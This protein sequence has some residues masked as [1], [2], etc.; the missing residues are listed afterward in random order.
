MGKVLECVVFGNT[1]R[2]KNR[3]GYLNVTKKMDSEQEA[4]RARQ[5]LAAIAL[6]GIERLRISALD[7]EHE[8][9]QQI[10]KLAPEFRRSAIN[11]LHYL[12][13]RH[14]DIREL[15]GLL[16]QLGMSSLGRMEAHVM[17][18]LNAVSELLSQLLNLAAQQGQPTLDIVTFKEGPELL[19]RNAEAIMGP[20]VPERGTRIMVTMPSEASADPGLVKDLLANGMEIMRINCAHDSAVE[21]RRMIDHLKDAETALGRHCK[22]SFDLAGPKLRTGSLAA[23]EPVIKVKPTRNALGNV[24]MPARMLLSRVESLAAC[25]AGAIP[26]DGALPSKVKIGD[27][28]RLVDA[29]GRKRKLIVVDKSDEGC[30]C[31]ASTTTYLVPGTLFQFSR[32]KHQLGKVPVAE[33]RGEHQAIH[34][35]PGDTLTLTFGDESGCDAIRDDSGKVVVP[36]SLTCSLSEV[37]R[38][39]RPG[40]RIFFDDGK[41]GGVIGQVSTERLVI[42]IMHVVGGKA[43]LSGEKGINLPDSHLD[44]P[45]L[46]VKD[47]Q[48]MEFAVDHADMLA[49]SFVQRPE[50]I[51]QLVGEL[52][53]LGRR[54]LGI[55]LKIETQ[56]AFAELPALLLEAMK[57]YPVA[58][59]VARG[60]LGV[61]VGFERLAE[62]QEE[63]LWLCEA[64]HVP[65]IWATQVLESLAKGGLPSRAEVTDSALSGRAECVMLNKGPYIMQTLQFLTNVL[66]RMETHRQKKTALLRRLSVSN[67]HNAEKSGKTRDRAIEPA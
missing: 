47:R 49:M 28:V 10:D 54:S 22:I 14:H 65:V 43:K 58:V 25:V 52:D 24:V 38:G 37:F 4:L 18:T 3:R 8:Y 50:D 41:I 62:V 21:W 33:F 9:A 40:E 64:A 23:G 12:A 17:A 5:E 7:L 67:L 26:I 31:E 16:T 56:Q 6:S 44:L 11:L 61:E 39:V 30:V 45:A 19:D 35:K 15:Q 66:D 13:V 53:R 2:I 46:S 34:L 60:D 57:H 27:R 63:I 59:M 32:G 48:D 20:H 55:V 42:D 51:R 1:N 29:R 36:A